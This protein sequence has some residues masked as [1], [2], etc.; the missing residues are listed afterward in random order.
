M[1]YVL[2]LVLGEETRYCL[3]L[4]NILP[5]FGQ[6]IDF[7]LSIIMITFRNQQADSGQIL[8]RILFSTKL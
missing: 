5:K 6:I 8:S 7:F 3:G 4:A 1:M 2:N